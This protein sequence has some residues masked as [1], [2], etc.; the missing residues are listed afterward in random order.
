MNVRMNADFF[1]EKSISRTCRRTY[2]V[3]VHMLG[4]IGASKSIRLIPVQFVTDEHASIHTAL[5]HNAVLLHLER[6][7]KK[8]KIVDG[9]PFQ[10]PIGIQQKQ[11]ST[12]FTSKANVKNISDLL[13]VLIHKVLFQSGYIRQN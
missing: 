8:V 13:E 1:T 3:N 10:R 12:V 2:F 9:T 5:W 4:A 7:S 11:I 6:C